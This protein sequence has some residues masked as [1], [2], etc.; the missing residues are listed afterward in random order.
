MPEPTLQ[1]ASPR[2]SAPDRDAPSA[3]HPRT[4]LALAVIVTCQLMVV[5][6]ATIVNIALPAIQRGLHFSAGTLAWTL[7]AY[8]LAFGGLLLLGGRAG[9]ILGRRRVFLA[10]IALFTLASLLGGLATGPAWL[11]AT[12]AAQGV[13]AAAAAPSA[14]ALIAT[15]FAEGPARNRALGVFSGVSAGGG[16]IGLLLGG[17]LTAWVSWRWIMFVNVPIGL[18]V[19]ALA[20]RVLPETVRHRGRPDLAGALTAT[21]GT[22]AIVYGFIHAATAGWTAATT[23]GPLGAGAAALA[24]FAVVETRAQQPLVP[25]RLLADR[26]RSGA[27]LVML[28]VTSGMFGMF[29]LISQ[30]VQDVLGYSA[31]QAGLAFLPMTVVLF[32]ASRIVP[33]LV[34]RVPA[35]V[36]VPA[37]LLLLATGLWWLT[38]L[39]PDAGFAGG[40]LGPMLLFGAGA[41]AAFM[42]LTM[43]V[44]AG[45]ARHEA[46]AAS[47]VLQTMQQVGGSIGLAV[48][49]SVSVTATRHATARHHAAASPGSAARAALTRGALTHGTTTGI[50]VAAVFASCAVLLSLLVLR[51]PARR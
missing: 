19:L 16:S 4:G 29:F 35:R 45:V 33:K 21:A 9:D 11:L 49:A 43:T 12:R 27:Y 37:G 1:T 47:G 26:A 40:L 25:P 34:G 2:P 18:A 20:P 28:L 24:G 42:P 13:G 17:A 3:R 5:L 41:G 22:T 30:F 23:L 6:D 51:A 48:L 32:T 14:L 15:T 39:S 50:G 38:G 36:L 46:G 7:N 10:G 8:T 44:L 31:I